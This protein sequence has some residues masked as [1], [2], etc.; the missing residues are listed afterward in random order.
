VLHFAGK[1]T[2][3]EFDQ[4]RREAMDAFARAFSRR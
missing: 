4:V 1:L 3:A 2:R